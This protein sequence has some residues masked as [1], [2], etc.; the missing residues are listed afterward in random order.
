MVR[1]TSAFC[2]ICK[3]RGCGGSTGFNQCHTVCFWV[4]VT[5]Q[6]IVFHR[7]ASGG[8]KKI[9]IW[10]SLNTTGVADSNCHCLIAAGRKCLWVSWALHQKS[11]TC[12]FEIV[13][14]VSPSSPKGGWCFHMGWRKKKRFYSSCLSHSWVASGSQTSPLFS[15]G[16]KGR[17]Q[18]L[19]PL[20]PGNSSF[21][22]GKEPL[23]LTYS[24]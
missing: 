8:L 9:K 20:A 7:L 15:S 19:L 10:I 16:L 3:I 21:G 23:P 17:E 13:R 1:F 24:G 5:C 14:R 22:R 12:L 18:L 6:L 2:S 11:E 4:F